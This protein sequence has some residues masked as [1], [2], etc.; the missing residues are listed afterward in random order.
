[1]V[2]NGEEAR[3]GVNDAAKR[4]DDAVEPPGWQFLA[5]VIVLAVFACI[6]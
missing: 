5:L 2:T 1:M 4:N 6:A 3:V